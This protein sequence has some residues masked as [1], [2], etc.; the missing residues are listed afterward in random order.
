[1]CLFSPVSVGCLVSPP[2]AAAALT[3]SLSAEFCSWYPFQS[4][5][6]P[7][8]DVL[9]TVYHFASQ[10]LWNLRTG[11][12]QQCAACTA[13]RKVLLSVSVEPPFS[14]DLSYSCPERAVLYQLWVGAGR[15]GGDEDERDSRCGGAERGRQGWEVW[16]QGGGGWRRD[17]SGRTGQ[18]IGKAG[19]RGGE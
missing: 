18:E 17:V 15:R 10:T 1:M 8:G 3:P 4:A 12:L 13:A 19:K 16:G 7:T 14:D 5:L 11:V 2:P 6:S 9:G